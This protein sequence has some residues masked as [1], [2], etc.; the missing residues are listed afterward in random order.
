MY[1]KFFHRNLNVVKVMWGKR[2]NLSVKSTNYNI[3]FTQFA[4]LYMKI[5][6]NVMKQRFRFYFK[7]Y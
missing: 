7:S 1:V 3:K 4:L 6:K 2:V 5:L